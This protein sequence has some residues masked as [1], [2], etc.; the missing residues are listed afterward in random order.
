MA[1]TPNTAACIATEAANGMLSESRSS[2]MSV[3]EGI[4][5]PLSRLIFGLGHNAD[6]QLRFRKRADHLRHGIPGCALIG[7]QIDGLGRSEAAA[8][9][10]TQQVDVY[11][12]LVQVRCGV[13]G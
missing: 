11:R 13:A 3:R 10:L 6:L 7:A 1:K 9:F 8:D 5:M 4:L 12:R 2:R